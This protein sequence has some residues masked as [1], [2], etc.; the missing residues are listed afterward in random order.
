MN[1]PQVAVPSIT[2]VDV[3]LQIAGPG[4][5]SFAFVADWHI[6]LLLA[7]TWFVVA[8]L[9][10]SG[11]LTFG[12][13]RGGGSFWIAGL[14]PVLIY[15]LYHP[16]LEVAMRGRTPG[17]RMAGVRVVTRTGDIPDAGALIL[18]NVLRLIDSLPFAYLVGL[19]TVVFTEQ[20][21]RIGDLAAGTLLIVDDADGDAS[22]ARL[23]TSAA[24]GLAPQAADLVHELLDRWPTLSEDARTNIARSLIARV[25]PSVSAGDLVG[26]TEPHFTHVSRHCKAGLQRSTETGLTAWLSSRVETWRRLTPTLDALERKRDHDAKD[27]LHAVELYRSLGRDLSIA[28]RILPASRVTRA[29]EQRYAKLHAI[30]YRKPHRWRTRLAV[31]FREEIP[32]TVRELRAPILWV[33]LLFALSAGAG[34]WLVST[35]P[36][37]IGLLASEEMIDGVE[38]GH[39]WTEGILNVAPSSLISVGILTNNIIVSLMAFCLGLLF[40]LGTFYIIAMNGVML[41][42]IFA[43]THQ[44]G[45]AGELLKFVTAHGVVELSVICVAGA[46]GVMLGESL[47]RPTHGTRRESFQRAA[48]KTSRLLVLCALLLVGCGFIEGYLSPDADFPMANRVIVG[49]GIGWSWSPP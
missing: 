24:S 49:F 31:L 23:G 37:T 16:V 18:R 30:I 3:A 10:V 8:T 15:F 13:G 21:V 38:R 29:L 5:R 39:L 2:G 47:I 35:Y 34:W 4:R 19:A 33:S 48:S 28:R 25:D 17:K 9:A 45:M 20:H 22:F 26:S 1:H 42:A 43:F 36:E 14:P 27:A 40:G 7:L 11:S 41:G 32:A 12:L 6:R 44:H 46:A